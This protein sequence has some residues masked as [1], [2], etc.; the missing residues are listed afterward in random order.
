MHIFNASVIEKG[1]HTK[2]FVSSYTKQM[3]CD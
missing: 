1:G 3:L 2:V